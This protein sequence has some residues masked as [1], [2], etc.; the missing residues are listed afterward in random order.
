MDFLDCLF[1][2]TLISEIIDII[3]DDDNDDIIEDDI[4]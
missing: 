1:G 4:Y 3:G 2:V